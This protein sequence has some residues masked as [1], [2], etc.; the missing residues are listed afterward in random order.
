LI[1]ATAKS[2]E[3]LLVFVHG[4]ANTFDFAMR[5]AIGMA[6]DLGFKGP[7]LVWS[8]PS[9]GAFFVHYPTS[10]RIGVAYFYDEDSSR[11]S[12]P[13]FAEFF[14]ALLSSKNRTTV[15]IF[16]HR[17]GARIV[18]EGLDRVRPASQKLAVRSVVFAAPDEDRTI[19]RARM[20][21]LQPSPKSFAR[22][23]DGTVYLS[24]EDSAI[25]L[26]KWLHQDPR[27]GS[28]GDDM[29]PF[30]EIETIDASSL[31][32]IGW[33]QHSYMFEHPRAI[34]DLRLVLMGR[35]RAGAAERALEERS[36]GGIPFWVLSERSRMQ[37]STDP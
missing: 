5:R 33:F 3:P 31:P 34:N 12:A 11:W 23:L 26:S 10:F 20:K 30:D 18:L 13:N 32:P 7:V 1:E 16:S 4:F 6:D 14:A 2:R 37:P 22:Y 25:A 28:G 24:K 17:M 15:D 21:A 19:F 36:K 8:W 9:T 27:A 29:I 35:F